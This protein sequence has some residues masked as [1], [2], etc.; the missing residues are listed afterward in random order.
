MDLGYGNS[1]QVM[2]EATA[3]VIQAS[4]KAQEDALNS[5]MKRYDDLLNSTDDTLEAI[6]ER[7][8]AQM[9]KAQVQ[10]TKWR[11]MGHGTYSALGQGQHSVDVA[12][13]FFDAAK[14]SER[15]VVHFHRPSTRICDVFHSHLEKLAAKHLETRFVKIDVEGCDDSNR[16]G[17]GSASFLVEKLGVVIMPTVLIVKDRKAV[18]HIRGFDELGGTDDFSTNLLA[19]VLGEHDGIKRTEDEEMPEELLQQEQSRSGVNSVRIRKAYGGRRTLRDSERDRKS[20][21]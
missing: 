7:R 1:N 14:K 18:H 20:V 2:G 11:E 12:R 6:R 10:R 5:E 3:A 8:L 4:F 19:Y 9:K 17:G 21:V 13:E 16:G 15:M